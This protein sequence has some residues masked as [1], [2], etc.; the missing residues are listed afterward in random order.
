MSGIFGFIPHEPDANGAASLEP[1]LQSM[2]D[3]MRP[4][5]KCISSRFVSDAIVIGANALDA[6]GGVS[7]D[8]DMAIAVVGDI[9]E[10]ERLYREL[11][12]EARVGATPALPEVLRLRF[13]HM[14]IDGL[15]GLN[16]LYAIAAWD[17][18]ARKLYLVTDRMGFRKLAYWSGPDGVYFGTRYTAFTHRPDFRKALDARAIF[19][20]LRFGYV[21]SDGTFF[22]DVRRV[23][24]G[25]CVEIGGGKVEERRYWDHAFDTPAMSHE[26]CVDEL[27]HHVRTAVERRAE[28]RI[29]AQITGGLDSR[30]IIGYLS[31]LNPELD[32]LSTTI[33]T[34][35][36]VDVLFGRQMARDLGYPHEAHY[37]DTSS[38]AAGAEE[39]VWR[40]EGLVIN[41]TCWR[42]AL[43]NWIQ[44]KER[45][46]T[47]HGF[48][49]I[50]PRM[51]PDIRSLIENPG[52]EEALGVIRSQ[53][54]D[55]SHEIDLSKLFRP[56][57][58]ADLMGSP[59][60]ILEDLYDRAPTDLD[61][62]RYDY[63]ELRLRQRN[64]QAATLEHFYPHTRMIAPLTDNDVVDFAA[65][66][67]VNSRANSQ[68]Y[69][70]AIVKYLP[71]ACRAPHTKTNMP[72][73][74]SKPVALYYRAKGRLQYHVIPAL[75]GGMVNIA[76]D[77]AYVPYRDSLKSGSREFM[78]DCLKHAEGFE[79]IFDL[80]YLEEVVREYADGKREGYGPAYTI[81]TLLL[82]HKQFG[83]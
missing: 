45:T 32:V 77:A 80:N 27:A 11:P 34:P 42:M 24:V 54:H 12:A 53:L 9:A 18:R 22:R 79:D 48:M 58:Y 63:V 83:S 38:F 46:H 71:R 37:L 29:A 49:S 10:V 31:E 30:I 21:L 81:N 59:D 15:C 56:E 23:P 74:P 47:T 35:R 40:T 67:P 62:H 14:G 44:Q 8:G 26:A 7:S 64:F 13:E 17:G 50:F 19:E 3:R 36:A 61:V 65:R 70:D 51:M 68:A 66:M 4:A 55:M 16:G 60:T 1:V 5:S 69:H 78:L 72:L 20:F 82:W 43:D 6:Q 25:T 76:P 33:G 75:T 2:H 28:G 52:R 73:A 57:V 39:S 41:H